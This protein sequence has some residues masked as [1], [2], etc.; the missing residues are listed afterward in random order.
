MNGETRVL[1]N[2][3][4]ICHSSKHV[5]LYLSLTTSGRTVQRVW[6]P[7]VRS[8][9]LLYT[10]VELLDVKPGVLT[11]TLTYKPKQTAT[12]DNFS[13]ISKN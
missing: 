9:I 12:V 6:V 4:R 3:Q 13:N 1:F 5:T 11:L 2:F 10:M 7:T 8:Y